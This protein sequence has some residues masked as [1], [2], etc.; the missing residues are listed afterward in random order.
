MA[1]ALIVFYE[2]RRSAAQDHEES[3]TLLLRLAIGRKELERASRHL[4]QLLRLKNVAEYEDRLLAQDD[5]EA[6]SKHLERF[7]G[8]A[9]TKLP[10]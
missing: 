4:T 8:W 3:V 9:R 1:D 7:R 10:D 2:G 5:A 6:A